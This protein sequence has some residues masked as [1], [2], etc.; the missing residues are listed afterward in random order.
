[1]RSRELERAKHIQD[2]LERLGLTK[3]EDYADRVKGAPAQLMDNGLLQTLA[4]YHA[5][6]GAHDTVARG[7]EDWLT[8]IGLL[9]GADPMRALI[10]L[11]ATTYRRCSEE[12]IA[13]FNWAKRL[14]AARVAM[15]AAPGGRS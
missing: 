10:E 2:C 6:E 9:R 12:A 5:K 13:W 3:L 7:V 1:M 15:S 4:F 11:D 14:A 8:R